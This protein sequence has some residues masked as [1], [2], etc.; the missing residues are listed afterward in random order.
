[1]SLMEVLGASFSNLQLAQQ[2]SSLAQSNMNASHPRVLPPDG[3][4][5]IPQTD[6][7][8]VQ[9]SI[10]VTPQTHACVQC[11]ELNNNRPSQDSACLFT[12]QPA[13]ES[14]VRTDVQQHTTRNPTSTASG[15]AGNHQVF[16]ECFIRLCYCV[17]LYVVLCENQL[18]VDYLL[19]L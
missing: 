18:N 5:F 6:A 9:P 15:A 7:L 2:S 11:S 16:V 4:N 14:L 17:C 3:T 19:F 13:I 8:P 1:M 12:G 10:S